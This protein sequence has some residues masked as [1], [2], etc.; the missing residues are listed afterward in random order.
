M[1]SLK[2]IFCSSLLTIPDLFHAAFATLTVYIY[3]HTALSTIPEVACIA[4]YLCIVMLSGDL[5]GDG[6]AL[7]ELKWQSCINSVQIYTESYLTGY[8]RPS[9]V[10]VCVVWYA[11]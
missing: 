2:P 10:L 9:S 6:S 11:A 8:A 1:R 4:L 3:V 5:A 7:Q